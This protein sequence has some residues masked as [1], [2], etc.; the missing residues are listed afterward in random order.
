MTCFCLFFLFKVPSVSSLA[1]PESVR[2]DKNVVRDKRSAV[3]DEASMEGAG[4]LSGKE[5]TYL[6]DLIGDS[7]TDEV[8][9]PNQPKIVPVNPETDRIP[10]RQ[11]LLLRLLQ[12]ETRKSGEIRKEVKDLLG[13]RKKGGR[14]YFHAVNCW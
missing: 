12:D 5:E 11:Q 1:L 3:L 14:C 9:L 4:G 10:A 2:E 6:K 8:L 13:K 7:L